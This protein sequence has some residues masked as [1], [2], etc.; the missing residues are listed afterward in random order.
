MNALTEITTPW[1]DEVRDAIEVD[2]ALDALGVQ[3]SHGRG[4]SANWALPHGMC[5]GQ[6]GDG[7]GTLFIGSRT[8][9]LH[10][11]KCGGAF[12]VLAV[13]GMV[14]GRDLPPAPWSADDPAVEAIRSEAE[15]QGWCTPRLPGAPRVARRPRAPLP[16]PRISAPTLSQPALAQEFNAARRA[17]PK[18]AGW[19]HAWCVARGWPADVAAVIAGDGEAPVTD[20]AWAG[21]DAPTLLRYSSAIDRPLLFAI[22]GADG[23][24]RSVSRRWPRAGAPTDGRPKAMAL[25]SKLVGSSADWGCRAFGSIPAAVDAVAY[26]GRILLVEGS[27]DFLVAQALVRLG[28]AHA[29]L[30]AESAGGLK[31]IA[32]AL[33]DQ[34]RATHAREVEVWTVPDVKRAADGSLGGEGLSAMR[35]AAQALAGYATVREILLNVPLDA[36]DVDLADVAARHLD[37]ASLWSHLQGCA[38]TL[39]EAFPDLHAPAAT[40]Y[41]PR[42]ALGRGEVVV[43]QASLG[44]GKTHRIAEAIQALRQKHGDLRV[45]A[46]NHRRALCRQAAIRF[47]IDC[48]EDLD[49]MIDRSAVICL[50]SLP[51]L[52]PRMCDAP[53]LLVIDEIEAVCQQLFGDTLAH[54]NPERPNTAAVALTLRRVVRATLEAGGNILLADAHAHPESI[55]ALLR[56][57]GVAQGA[58]WVRHITAA[59]LDVVSHPSE[60]RLVAELLAH[61]EGGRRVALA[62]DSRSRSRDLQA[63][64]ADQG[65]R[66]KSYT[67]KMTR[68]RRREL[69]DVEA[70]WAP[71]EADVIIYTP[72]VD[73]GV[74]HD[75]ADITERFDAVFGLFTGSAKLGAATIQQMMFRCRHVAEHH[76]YIALRDDPRSTDLEHIRAE[77]HGRSTGPEER[78][79]AVRCVVPARARTYSAL[80]DFEAAIE[81]MARLRA[82]R[83]RP[84]LHAMYTERHATLTIAEDLEKARRRRLTREVRAMG[85]EAAELDAQAVLISVVLAVDAYD[86]LRRDHSVDAATAAQ[87]EKSR[88]VRQ[89]G[90]ECIDLD[91]ITRDEQGRM[92]KRARNAVSLRLAREGHWRT[93]AE[94][95]RLALLNGHGAAR[96]GPDLPLL[97]AVLDLLAPEELLDRVIVPSPSEMRR[98]IPDYEWSIDSLTDA[99]ERAWCLAAQV[100]E[101]RGVHPDELFRGIRARADDLRRRPSVFFNAVLSWIG[102]PRVSRRQRLDGRSP[103]WIYAVDA[104]RLNDW[105]RRCMV[106]SARQR[107]VEVDPLDPSA[108]PWQRSLT[109]RSTWRAPR[110][111]DGVRRRIVLDPQGIGWITSAMDP[112]PGSSG[113]EL[114]RRR[115]LE[116]FAD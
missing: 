52:S 8:S 104:D 37:A 91:L 48:Y 116:V 76:V 63:W 90:A 105:N 25:S 75:P 24:V 102:V 62:T 88:M 81:R 65:Y 112:E 14:L 89:F 58:R 115:I 27:P 34:L 67:G 49:G 17:A 55:N 18:W 84:Q 4:A 43:L 70:A 23:R 74:N 29:A 83:L 60:A 54:R 10:C 1:W 11:R 64:L 82:R 30:G 26:G 103:L 85:R 15:S 97:S 93:L 59:P 80:L 100:A 72:A 42:L 106:E 109:R 19:L 98:S 69:A 44:S 71:S 73:A 78:V 50:N 47:G 13:V 40:G 95:D 51:R 56:F 9:A 2:A 38:A 21:P 86:E 3:P 53:H 61:L 57:C 22:R 32:T 12:G 107:G 66:V 46:T 77:L 41:L 79:R 39:Y 87:V 96:P 68:G 6:H 16:S 92:S 113:A 35:A 31:K 94:K 114:S 7:R 5:P 33:G 20:V 101:S 99:G 108:P 45:I 28:F 110:D 111:S 36:H